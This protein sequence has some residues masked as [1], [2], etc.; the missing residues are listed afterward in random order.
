MA[1]IYIFFYTDNKNNKWNLCQKKKKT[2][3]LCEFAQGK[4]I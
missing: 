4:H 2:R 1:V 3:K